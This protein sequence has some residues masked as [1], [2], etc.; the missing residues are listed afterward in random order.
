VDEARRLRDKATHRLRVVEAIL[1]GLDDWAAIH[2]A[3]AACATHAQAI[4]VLGEP[5]FG[6]EPI[7]AS[8]VLDTP[9]GRCVGDARQAMLDEAAEL[10]RQVEP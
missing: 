10:R 8:Y 6:F 2:G 9:L 4:A 1:R 3:V 7:L 5:P